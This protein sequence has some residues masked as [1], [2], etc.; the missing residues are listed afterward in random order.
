MTLTLKQIHDRCEE[1][2]ECLLWKQSCTP[3]GYPRVAN[4]YAHIKAWEAVHGPVPP[5]LKVRRDCEETRCCAVP[6]MRLIT[7]SQQNKLAAKRGAWKGPARIAAIT[8]AMRARG[9]LDPKKVQEI[10]TSDETGAELAVRM[11]VSRSLISKVRKRQA[12]AGAARNA[13][14]FHQAA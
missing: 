8:L 3:S 11:N 10:L 13:S 9:K 6:H 4:G 1:V 5:G 7:R 12:W 2:G 14:V